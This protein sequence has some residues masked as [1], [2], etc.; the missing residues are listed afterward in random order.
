MRRAPLLLIG[1]VTAGVLLVDGCGQNTRAAGTPM[2]GQATHFSIGVPAN[3]TA[4]IPANFTLT[5]LD[6]ANNAATS[7]AG[8][9]QISTSDAKASFQPSSSINVANGNGSFSVTFEIVGNQ[10]VSAVDET[11]ASLRGVAGPISVSRNANSL[12]ISS[13]A[14]PQGTVGVNYNGRLGPNCKSGS[15]GCVCILITGLGIECHFALHGFALTSTGGVQPYKWSWAPAPGSSLPPGLGIETVFVSGSTGCCFFVTGIGG[16]PTAAGSF[17]VVVT[18]SDSASPPAQASAQYGINIA[19]SSSSASPALADV[20][21]PVA[22]HHHYKLIDL[23]TFGGP[24]SHVNPGSGQ[25]VGNFASVLNSQGAVTGW[26]DTSTPDPFPSFCF[27]LECFVVHAFKWKN[28]FKTDLGALPGGASSETNW[29]TSNGIIVGVSENGEIDPLIPGFPE[30]HATLWRNGSITDLGTL[31]GGF[32][33]IA[34]AANGRGQVVGLASNMTPDPNSMLGLGFQTRAFLWQEGEMQ[35]LGTLPGGTDSEAVLINENGEVV[36]WSYN[37][38]SAAPPCQPGFTLT[39]GSFVWDKERGLRDIGGLGGSCT[40][41]TDINDRGQVIG[42]SNLSGDASAHAFL[43]EDDTFEDLGGSLGGNFQGAFALNDQGAAVGFATLPG[44]ALFH[45][46]LWTSVGNMLDLGVIGDDPSSNADSINSKN[47]IVGSSGDF[48][49]DPPTS[50]VFLWENGEMVDLNAL[51][52][53]TSTLHMEFPQKINDRGE[54]AGSGVDAQGNEHA[55]LAIPCDSEHPGLEGC[56]Y[57]TVDGNTS[58]AHAPASMR[59]SVAPGAETV[60]RLMRFS[61]PHASLWPGR[62]LPQPQD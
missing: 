55:F 19:N 44:D 30:F 7:Y 39:T 5:A 59:T 33:S 34:N 6:A 36:G 15:R 57:T 52:P 3:V 25:N 53:E 40:I 29:I 24:E 10:T 62:V 61:R 35:D 18:V 54:I 20:A 1:M 46:T 41:A 14:P 28:G 16:S 31:E 2:P 22:K 32:E 9:V 23:G 37:S 38:S 47:Q 56:D 49:T 4:G 13:G 43:W 42:S 50:R 8:T 51:V 11:N 21:T 12:F 48:S 17:E 26:A 27:S 58:V 45:A 60:R